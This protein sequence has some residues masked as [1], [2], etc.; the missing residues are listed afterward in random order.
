MGGVNFDMHVDDK[1]VRDALERLS[2]AACDPS[3]AMRHIG[4]HQIRS[5]GRRL[6]ARERDWGPR[7]GR[8]EKS[9]TMEVDGASVTVGSAEAYAAIQQEGGR[10]KPKNKYLALPVDPLMRRR[11]VWPS[12]LPPKSLKFTPVAEIRIGSHSWIGPALLRRESTE[13]EKRLTGAQGRDASGRFAKKGQG[14]GSL[15]V[16]EVLF[17]LVKG[18]EIDPDPYLVFGPDEQAF[19]LVTIKR[20][21]AQA[22][23]G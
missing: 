20:H 18:V 1:P 4:L 15:K 5:A 14:G 8:L 7:T 21:L 13:A 3:P 9:L 6:R 23:K 11:G 2:K 17:A 22:M 19:A 16:G 10:I 12:D